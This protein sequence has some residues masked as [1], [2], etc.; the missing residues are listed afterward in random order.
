MNDSNPS[1]V[2]MGAADSVS[3][4]GQGI[5]VLI[6]E[7]NRLQAKILEDRLIKSGYTVRVGR[8][9]QKAFD[10]AKEKRP[11]IIVSDIEMPNM[12]GHEL[13]RAIK[14]D[15]SL[16]SVPLILLSTLSEP[17]D[18]IK[19]L[20]CGADNYVTKPYRPAYLI[21][22]MN[23]LLKT[24]IQEREEDIL[25]LEVTLAGTVY[26]VRSGRQQVLNLLVSTFENAVE[27]NHEL[28]R[29]NEDLTIAKETLAKSNRSLEEMNGR[30][31]RDLDAAAKI[32]HSLL[33][34]KTVETE[35][36]EFAWKYLP[37]D[38]LAGDFLN[39]FRLDDDHVALFVVDVSGHGVASSLLSVTVGRVMSPDVGSSS[40]LTRVGPN[41]ETIITPP[42]EVAAEL[43]RRFPMED[44]GH[45]YFTMVYAVLNLK[46]L[47]LRYAS[48]GHEAMVH[49]PSGQPPRLLHAEGFAIG[50]MEDIEYDEITVQ[51]AAGDRLYLYSDGIPEALD[52]DL[53]EYD[54]DRM[55]ALM[56]RCRLESIGESVETICAE[57]KQ[58]C[59]IN[60]PK[61]DI[62]ILGVD[63]KSP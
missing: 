24:T 27:K 58:W 63:L 55:L 14:S 40:L 35:L 37:C 51:L 11:D 2:S 4:G 46:T 13:C 22:R 8:D 29:Y 25:E 17:E 57:I 48:A 19:G 30:M 52:A 43:N 10:L 42:A 1:D 47:E 49:I 21:S 62:S 7:D 60:G 50:W 53:E 26:K 3:R 12:T 23:S 5:D 56:H 54:N 45:L 59:R 34:S 9:G 61:D 36:A 33:P 28:L 38:E 41:G 39:Y 18:I 31:T 32:Q 6:A 15:P 20:D 16:R 44:Q